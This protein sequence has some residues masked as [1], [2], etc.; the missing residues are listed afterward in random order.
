MREGGRSGGVLF[1]VG[2]GRGAVGG[3]GGKER[4]RPGIGGEMER[5]LFG[6]W[7]LPLGQGILAILYGY[8]YTTPVCVLDMRDLLQEFS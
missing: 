2:V 1:D 5:S 3:S 8:G 6:A 7:V 4:H